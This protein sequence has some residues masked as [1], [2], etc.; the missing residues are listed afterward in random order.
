MLHRSGLSVGV[1]WPSS[2]TSF[3]VLP[4]TDLTLRC[5]LLLLLLIAAAI[6]RRSSVQSSSAGRGVERSLDIKF[7]P[8]F[9]RQFTL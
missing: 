6:V 7:V 1:P 3:L 5:V 4:E 9:L 8:V 2:R